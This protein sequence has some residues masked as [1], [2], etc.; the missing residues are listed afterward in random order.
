MQTAVAAPEV[1]APVVDT[2]VAETA[3]DAKSIAA[4]APVVTPAPA[5]VADKAT[6][7]AIVQAAGLTWVESNPDRVAQALVSLQTVVPQ[8]L[9]RERKPPVIVSSAP[10]VQVETRQG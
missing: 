9:G 10:L 8:K 2:A 1:V 4:P 5:P 6:L 3:V 7:H